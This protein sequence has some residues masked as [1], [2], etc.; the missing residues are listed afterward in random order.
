MHSS[1]ALARRLTA[2]GHVAEHVDDAG[3][4]SASDRRIW[5]YALNHSAVIVTKDED[6]PLRKG[7]EAQGPVVVWLR[8]GNTR[9]QVL[10]EWFEALLPE[11][12]ASLEKG[13]QVIELV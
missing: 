12:T 1:P 9:K 6:F 8:I 10:L 7:L 13:E 3:L 11:M 5:D 4:A 2:L